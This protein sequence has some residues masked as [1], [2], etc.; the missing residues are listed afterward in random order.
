MKIKINGVEKE[1]TNGVYLKDIVTQ[2]SQN[3]SRVIAEVN[4]RI[5]KSTD[6]PQTAISEGDAIELV[7]FVGGG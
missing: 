1:F 6:W 7:S 3:N 2:V 5:I 4:G